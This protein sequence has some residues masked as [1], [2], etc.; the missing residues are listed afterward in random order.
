[1]AHYRS[2]RKVYLRGWAQARAELQ[3]RV[4][5]IFAAS[6]R[7][8]GAREIARE[9]RERQRRVCQELYQKVGETRVVAVRE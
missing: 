4:A 6:R 5:A 2:R 9:E 3:G 8:V 7:A 1:M